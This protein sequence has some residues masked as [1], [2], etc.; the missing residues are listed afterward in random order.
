[1]FNG[2]KSLK[3][4]NIGN[5]NIDYPT[6]KEDMFEGCPKELVNKIKRL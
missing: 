2:C 5:F 3:E 4:L 6:Y 1:M